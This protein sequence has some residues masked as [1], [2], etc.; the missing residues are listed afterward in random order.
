MSALSV[1][2]TTQ[3][4]GN[5]APVTKDTGGTSKGNPAAGSGTSSSPTGVVK[6]I[7]TADKAGAGILTLLVICGVIG[8]SLWIIK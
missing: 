2:G 4:Q 1:L 6:P 5:M 8:G 3:I 7:T